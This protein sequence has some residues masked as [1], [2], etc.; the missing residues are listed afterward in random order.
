MRVAAHVSL[1]GAELTP[2]FLQTLLNDIMDDAQQ[3]SISIDHIQKIVAEHFDIRLADM[4]SRRRPKSI[5]LP[6]QIAMYLAREMT[7]N[8][9]KDIGDAFGGKDHGTVIHACKSV[10]TKMSSE[11]FRRTLSV[12]TEK[13]KKI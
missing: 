8:P 10:S 4:T 9:L 6:R 1:G 11:D 12:L 3:R 13:I 5:A 2:E 7:R